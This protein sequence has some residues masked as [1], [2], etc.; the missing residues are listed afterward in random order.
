MSEVNKAI[1][2]RV[3]EEGMNKHDNAVIAELYPNCVYHSPAVG[4]LRGEAYRKFVA[5]VLAAFP[6][7]QATVNDQLAEGDKVMTRWSFTGTHKGIFMGIASTGRK[8]T[9]T[10]MC[11]D[12]IVNGKIV[13]EWEEWD[14]LGMMRQLGLVPHVKVAEPVAA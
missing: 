8:V 14:S 1:I 2:R 9:M 7:A 5:S 11:I 10:G 3:L 4:E 6:D 13:E 12:R